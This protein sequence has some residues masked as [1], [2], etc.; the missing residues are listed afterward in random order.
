VRTAYDFTARTIDG[1]S[2]SLATYTGQ[3]LLVVNTA[4]EC[5]A[6][7]QYEGLEALHERFSE[8]GLAVLGFPCDQFG[9]QEPGDEQAI[10]AFCTQ[11]Y[12]VAFPM[13]AK[14]DVNGSAAHPLFEWLRAES[15]GAD[16]EW[17]FEK[18]LVDAEGRLVRRYGVRTEPADLVDDI[19]PLL[20]A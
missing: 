20:P 19:E 4:S 18:F 10:K 17:N 3:A 16:I 15:G 6:T 9:H 7:P 12:G 13:F 8:R 5:G 1:D 14:V 2:Q 11:T